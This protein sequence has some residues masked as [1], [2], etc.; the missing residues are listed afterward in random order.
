MKRMKDRA[1]GHPDTKTHLTRIVEK[2]REKWK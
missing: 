1:V 2:L